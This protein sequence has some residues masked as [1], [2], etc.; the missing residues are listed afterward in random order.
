MKVIFMMHS[1]SVLTLSQDATYQDMGKDEPA[2]ILQLS[3]G[4]IFTCNMT[5]RC[6]LDLLDSPRSLGDAVDQLLKT[7]DV[8][9]E[10]LER[11]LI[12][13]AEQL[14]AA[15]LIQLS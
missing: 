11:D 4:R 13:L 2:V 3:T 14:L 8:P 6:F 1:D 15:G 5:T 7:F 12:K 10:K 9:R